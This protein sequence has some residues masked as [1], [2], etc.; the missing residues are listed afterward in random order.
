MLR[1]V[2]CAGAADEAV[3]GDQLQCESVDRALFGSEGEGC[4]RGLLSLLA[5]AQRCASELVVASVAAELSRLS[6]RLAEGVY[7]QFRGIDLGLRAEVDYDGA[8]AVQPQ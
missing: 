6:D 3:V 5:Q 7:E 4:W 1:F 2:S 8:E